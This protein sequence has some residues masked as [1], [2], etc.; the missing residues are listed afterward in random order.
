M[1]IVGKIKARVYENSILSLQLSYKNCSKIKILFKF[2][3]KHP[4]IWRYFFIQVQEYFEANR[5]TCLSCFTI[6]NKAVTEF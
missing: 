5:S 3:K 2:L 1:L 6:M 4:T